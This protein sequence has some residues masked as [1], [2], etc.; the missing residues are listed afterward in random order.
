[1]GRMLVLS[2]QNDF[3]LQ[4]DRISHFKYCSRIH[5]VQNRINH[6]ALIER[7]DILWNHF[8]GFSNTDIMKRRKNIQ[9]NP[10]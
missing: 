2:K 5:T 9:S 10:F 7:F 8:L 3:L 1:M 4:S 6:L